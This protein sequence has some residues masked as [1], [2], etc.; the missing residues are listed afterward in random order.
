MF[1]VVEYVFEL[2]YEWK[3]VVVFYVP[4]KH[5]QTEKESLFGIL[6]YCANR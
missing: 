1:L 2:C 6:T 4:T 5:M 3:I